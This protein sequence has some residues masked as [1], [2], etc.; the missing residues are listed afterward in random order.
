MTTLKDTLDEAMEEKKKNNFKLLMDDPQFVKIPKIGDMVKGRV[1]SVSRSLVRLDLDGLRLG[2][3]R[4]AELYQAPEYLNLKAGDEADATVMELENENG[5]LELSFRAV[6]H[7]KA[8]ANILA[9]Q[10]EGAVV[11]AKVTDANRGGLLLMMDSLAGFMPVSQLG[12]EHYPR[13]PGGDK[14]KIL[15]KL[16]SFIGQNLQVKVL[17]V[18][19]KE[20][21]LIVSEKAVWEAEKKNL[22]DSYKVGDEVEGIVSAL[23]DFGAFVKF[24]AAARPA[25]CGERQASPA[26][27]G[28]RQAS[29]PERQESASGGDEVEGLV[30]ISEIAWQR[31][32]HPRDILKVGEKVKAQIIQINGSK[33]FLSL[34][35]LIEDPWKKVGEKY[36]VGQSVKG[37]VVKINPFGLFVELDPEIHGLAHVSSLSREASQ[38]ISTL[39]KIGDSLD[40]EIISLEPAEHRLG[41]KLTGVK[42]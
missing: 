8:W 42:K 15:E 13:V 33:I 10:K 23:T 11:S 35:R 30:H 31:L 34:K 1:L 18:D 14:N 21:K 9:W 22:L 16:R 37:K 41:L 12:P 20:N 28:E 2:V 4:G 40:F 5:E 38:D 6:G 19:E 29:L 24:S 32:D 3:V 7:R 17:D 39:A 36:Q 27:S 25:N 26:A